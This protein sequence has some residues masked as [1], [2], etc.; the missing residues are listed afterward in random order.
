MNFARNYNQLGVKADQ[1]F[2]DKEKQ[3]RRSPLDSGVLG[4][5]ESECKAFL[6]RCGL[7]GKSFFFPPT[8]MY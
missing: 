3:A 2:E 6:G 8:N 7:S 5:R 1:T 4:K